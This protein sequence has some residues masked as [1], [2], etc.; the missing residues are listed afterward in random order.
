MITSKSVMNPVY[1]SLEIDSVNSYLESGGWIMEHTQTRALEKLIS[2]YVDSNFAAMVPSATAGLLI[3]A[4][5]ADIKPGDYFAV[6]AYT[7]AATVNGAILLGG[8]PC[9]VDVDPIT[10]TIDF[11][12]IPS[13]CK[14]V[15]VSSINGRYPTNAIQ[16][17]RK[18]QQ[19]GIFVIEDSAQALGSTINDKHIG[20][21]GDIGVY[22]FG[23]PKI[24][25]TGQGG[26]LVTNNSSIN[27]RI[28]AIKNFGREVTTGEIYNSLGL[29]F[30]FTDLQASFGIPQM[31]KIRSIIMHK[32]Y[33]FKEYYNQLKDYVEFIATDLTQC[34]P[35][36][37]EILVNN[38]VQ[39]H[40][41]LLE[42]D[43]GSRTV[44]TSLS[45][46]PYHSKWATDTPVTNYLT[47]RA[48]ILP[49]Q[50]DITE[51]NIH[52]IA[53]IIKNAL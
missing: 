11:S 4:M 19:K 47:A 10:Y 3:A 13:K 49:S 51:E 40:K 39:L 20:T 14:V 38:P 37:P 48:L 23:A 24:I 12:K 52:Y 30:K 21:I 26:C 46:Q 29:N 9:I 17:I 5:I 35:T 45:R 16:E 25:T 43:I 22:S 32:R 44:Y 31:N 7:Q 27:Q 34:T 36:Y 50:A 28:L 15:F 8:I 18:L 53:E 6:S 2:D 1:N 42:F 33:I 41:S